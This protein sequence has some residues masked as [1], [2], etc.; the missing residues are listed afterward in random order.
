MTT[1]IATCFSGHQLFDTLK[2]QLFKSID[3][4]GKS[5][6]SCENQE[7]IR[8]LFLCRIAQVELSILGKSEVIRDDVRKVFHSTAEALRQYDMKI[9]SKLEPSAR[10]ELSAELCKEKLMDIGTLVTMAMQVSTP[11]ETRN[12]ETILYLVTTFLDKLL[13]AQ[14]RNQSVNMQKFKALIELFTDELKAD[15]E[16]GTSMFDYCESTGEVTLQMVHPNNLVDA[17]P[18]I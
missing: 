11:D 5:I 18:T 9:R 14:K 7:I 12:Y 3:K 17:K 2:L 6:E 4:A 8:S 1:T 16:G 15:A 10:Q 13:L